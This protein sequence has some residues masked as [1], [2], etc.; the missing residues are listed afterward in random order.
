MSASLELVRGFV[1]EDA[2]STLTTD[3]VGA[4][5]LRLQNL[6]Y[7]EF[8]DALQSGR[9]AQRCNVLAGK[10]DNEEWLIVSDRLWQVSV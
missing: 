2:A 8:R 9:F 3:D 5:R 10:R 4:L 6:T 1:G 7:V